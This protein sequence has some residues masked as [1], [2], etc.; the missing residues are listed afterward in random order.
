MANPLM[1]SLPGEQRKDLP[2][3]TGNY[4][5]IYNEA[6]LGG[7]PSGPTNTPGSPNYDPTQPSLHQPLPGAAPAGGA[8][9][10]TADPATLTQQLT[11]FFASK[12]VPPT[13]VP[14]WVSKAPEL[15]ARGKEINNPN[16]AMDRL[17][18][19]DSLGGGGQ[20]SGGQSSAGGGGFGGGATMGA[21]GGD[22]E[23]IM[24]MDPGYQFRLGEGLKGIERGAAARGTLLTGGTQKALERYGQDYASGEFGNIF[25]RNLSLA[26]LG[27]N[28]AAGVGNF[29]SQFAANS[30]NLLT[31]QGNANAAGTVGA[32]NAW[33]GTLG[34]IGNDALMYYLL[35]QNKGGAT[36]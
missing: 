4:N 3:N 31:Q 21:L 6:N 11:A 1:N 29:G 13:E 28:A 5:W 17:N 24:K 23:S 27:E 2:P 12:G 16:Y 18:A 14:Y 9:D 36:A 15:V 34:N 33:G 7:A 20:A 8:I 26:Q 22:P 25:G 32:A 10:W 30:G 19:A 35:N